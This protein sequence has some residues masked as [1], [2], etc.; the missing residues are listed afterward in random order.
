[1]KYILAF[2]IFI[3]ILS[4]KDKSGQT[5]KLRIKIDSLENIIENS[6]KPGFGE[7]MS[8]VQT[9]HAKLWF[10][11]KNK[12]WQLADF[13]IHEIIEALNN[14]KKYQSSRKESKSIDMI[15]PAI[16]SMKEAIKNKNQQF[17]NHSYMSLTNAC[18]KCHALTNFE[19]N[20]VKVPE[21]QTFS[22][23]DFKTK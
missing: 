13:E 20:I 7:F 10:A 19:F 1:M 23:Q 2:I 22:N 17:F 9:H 5:G 16:D 3:F 12:N 21:K 11:G 18:N 14:I 6:Y 8:S 4:C 15:I